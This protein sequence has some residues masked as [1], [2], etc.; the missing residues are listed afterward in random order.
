M[1]TELPG[2]TSY[3]GSSQ[4]LRG[5]PLSTRGKGSKGLLEPGI[6]AGVGTRST[7][8]SSFDGGREDEDLSKL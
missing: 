6:I 2:H 8:N 3:A 1:L 5:H 7:V 4:T